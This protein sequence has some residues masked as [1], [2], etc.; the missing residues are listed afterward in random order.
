MKYMIIIYDL[1]I[2]IVYRETNAK[3]QSTMNALM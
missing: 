2:G 3:A 1:Y